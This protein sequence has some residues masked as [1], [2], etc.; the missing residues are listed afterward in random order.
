[1]DDIIALVELLISDPALW[2]NDDELFYQL[3]LKRL[4]N[5]YA[6]EMNRSS[7]PINS[8]RPFDLHDI[9]GK[10]IDRLKNSDLVAKVIVGHEGTLLLE[11]MNRIAVKHYNVAGL[12]YN[13]DLNYKSQYIIRLKY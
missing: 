7:Q 10:M 6:L 4:I 9:V 12:I 3:K 13:Q 5:E 8:D 1:M 11:E 2:H